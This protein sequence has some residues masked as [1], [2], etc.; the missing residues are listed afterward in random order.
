M[1]ILHVCSCLNDDDADDDDAYSCYDAQLKHSFH[2]CANMWR[3]LCCP[4]EVETHSLMVAHAYHHTICTTCTHVHMY[5]VQWVPPSPY[6][7]ITLPLC[8]HDLTF[9]SRS[10]FNISNKESLEECTIAQWINMCSCTWQWGSHHCG[11]VALIQIFIPFFVF[12]F[13]FCVFVY[14]CLYLSTWQ[15]VGQNCGTVALT[16]LSIPVLPSGSPLGASAWRGHDGRCA[17]HKCD[18]ECTRRWWTRRL[19]RRPTRWSRRSTKWIPG[20]RMMECV[21]H[22]NAT[23][24]VHPLFVSTIAAA[25]TA[26]VHLGHNLHAACVCSWLDA[27]LGRPVILWPICQLAGQCTYW[28][29]GRLIILLLLPPWLPPSSVT[30]WP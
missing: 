23:E 19:T 26:T 1:R 30:P 10:E 20:G 28:W 17:T 11:T 21:Q 3:W 29:R 18:R 13:L 4:C 16:Q 6:L 2:I 27:L 14:L 9:Y 24:Q 25:P 8:G 22:T 5:S 12:V 15:W 7:I